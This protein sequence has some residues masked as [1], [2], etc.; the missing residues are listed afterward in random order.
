MLI[1][2][3]SIRTG[4][5]S[6]VP[7]VWSGPAPVTSSVLTLRLAGLRFLSAVNEKVTRPELSGVSSVPAPGLKLL[8]FGPLVSTTNPVYC[9][10]DVFPLLKTRTRAIE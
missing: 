10:A 4:A 8:S 7:K 9:G 1:P 6:A 5:S 2:C 3:Q